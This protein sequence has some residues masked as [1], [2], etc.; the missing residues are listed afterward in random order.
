MKNRYKPA[1]LAGALMLCQPAIQAKHGFWT[2]FGIGTSTGILGSKII[3]P[4]HGC[5]RYEYPRYECPRTRYVEVQ[6][7]PSSSYLRQEIKDLEQENYGLIQEKDQL[8]QENNSLQRKLE[9]E[10]GKRKKYQQKINS[11][12]KK[13]QKTTQKV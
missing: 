13:L 6:R 9:Q 2:G 1:I 8:E 10:R 11:L 3:N 12:E 5:P 7:V 4:G